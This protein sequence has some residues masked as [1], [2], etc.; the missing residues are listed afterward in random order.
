MRQGR[1][2]GHRSVENGTTVYNQPGGEEICFT[3]PG[4]TGKVVQKKEDE[5]RWLLLAGITGDCGGKNGWVWR[6]DENQDVTL[7]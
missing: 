1:R 4:D 2:V 5:P 6:G 3:Q 7:K